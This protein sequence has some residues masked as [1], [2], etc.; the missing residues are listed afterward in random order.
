[1]LPRITSQIQETE[2]RKIPLH[3]SN[4]MIS[5]MNMFS[6]DVVLSDQHWTVNKLGFTKV[7]YSFSTRHHD[8]EEPS[9]KAFKKRCKPRKLIQIHRQVMLLSNK[10][11]SPRFVDR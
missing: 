11:N 9:S 2:S 5:L 4:G 1:M 8:C 7:I 6:A 3:S 10:P